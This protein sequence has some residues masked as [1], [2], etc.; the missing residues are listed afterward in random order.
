MKKKLSNFKSIPSGF[1]KFS[2]KQQAEIEEFGMILELINNTL[3]MKSALEEK[4]EKSLQL[5][6]EGLDIPMAGVLRFF[7]NDLPD[8]PI[9]QIEQMVEKVE[10]FAYLFPAGTSLEM[11][12]AFSSRVGFPD[13]HQSF[14]SKIVSK[15]LG[16]LCGKEEVPTEIFK[17]WGKNAKA[18]T[19]GIEIFIPNIE[20]SLAYKWIAEGIC[21]HIALKVKSLE[22]I[23]Q[24]HQILSENNPKESSLKNTTP[25]KNLSE[26]SATLYCDKNVSDYIV[27][28]EFFYK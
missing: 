4:V 3:L 5:M 23:S 14:P 27:R 22:S 24:I 11:M 25:L 1:Q 26:S 21:R 28:L 6:K 7:L 8:G 16:S 10:H 15:E 17:A 18:E 19:V 12:N 9:N 20:A 2:P 13:S